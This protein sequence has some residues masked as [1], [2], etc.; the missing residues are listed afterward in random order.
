MVSDKDS[1][2][3]TDDGPTVQGLIRLQLDRYSKITKQLTNFRKD[4]ETRKTRMYFKKKIEQIEALFA[5]FSTD[6]K[7]IVCMDIDSNDDYFKSDIS[8]SFENAYFDVY[9][10]ICDAQE[11]AFPPGSNESSQPQQVAQP[12]H[13]VSK[14]IIQVPNL[15]VPKFSGRIIDWPGF[16]DNFNRMFN[17]NPDLNAIQRFHFLKEA[18]PDDKDIDIHQ[19]TMTEANYK[20]AWDLLA[21]RYHIPR[22]LF[23]HNMNTLYNLPSL[24]KEK[25]DDI[26]RML[27]VATVCMTAMEKIDIPIRECDHWIAHFLATKLSKETH[28]AWEYHLG[29]STSVPT[30]ARF[31]EFLNNRLI[32]LD[33]IENRNTS[34]QSDQSKQ[35]DATKNNSPSKGNKKSNVNK[36]NVHSTTKPDTTTAACPL[37]QGQHTIRR[38]QDFLSKTCYERKKD[39]DQAKICVNCLGFHHISKC[40]SSKN[41]LQCG[42]RHHTLLHFPIVV[43]TPSTVNT[44]P[45]LHTNNTRFLSA[46]ATQDGPSSK[47]LLATALVFAHNTQNNR[48]SVLRALIDQGSE[49][50]L[51]SERAVQTLQL[52]RTATRAEICGVG[53]GNKN[54]CRFIVSLNLRSQMDKH[55]D[56]FISNAY[57]LDRLSSRLPSQRLNIRSWPHTRDLVLADPNFHQSQHIDLIIGADIFAQIILPDIRIGSA[58]QP[59]AQRTKFGWI[60]SGKTSSTPEIHSKLQCFH[61][62]KELEFLVQRFMEIDQVPEKRVLSTEDEWCEEFF[63]RTHVRQANGKYMVRL[64][65]KTILDP[66]QTIG[67]SRQMALNRFHQ[68]HRKLQRNEKLN[69]QYSKGIEEYFELNQILPAPTMEEQH[70]VKSTSDR[71]F[72]TACTLPHHAIIKEDS[73]TTKVRI[74]FDASAKTSNGKSL[75]DILCIGP[76]L[77]NDLPAI[78]LNWRIHKFV[79]CA[80]IQKMYRCIDMHPDD[81]HYQR[82]LWQGNENKI[83]EYCLT[84]VTF[85]T[86]SAPYTAIRIM[87]QLAEDEKHRFPLAEKV[88]KHEMYVDDIQTGSHSTENCIEI[89]NQLI[90]ALHSG[91]FELRKWSSNSTEI[92]QSIPSEHQSICPDVDFEK[93]MHVKTLGLRWQPS[94]DI[95][96]YKF[97][98]EFESRITKRSILSVT[99]RLYDPLGFI[100]PIIT[101]AKII[102][103]TIWTT[104]VKDENDKLCAV[105]WDENLPSN[106]ETK[107]KQFL[108]DLRD[109]ENI[110]IPRWLKYVPHGIKS[111]QLHAFCDGSSTAYAA[112]VYLR[113]QYETGEIHTQLLIAKSKVTPT[114]PITIPRTELCGAV[115]AAKLV[116]WVIRNINLPTHDRTPVYYWT[117]ATIVLHWIYGDLNRW[118]TFVANRISAILTSSTH[119][120]WNHVDT[121]ENPADCATRGLSPKQLNEFELWWNGPAWLTNENSEYPKFNI[122]D[123]EVHDEQME[124]K[125]IKASVNIATK[126]SE[127][128]IHKYSSLTKLVRITAYVRRYIHNLRAKQSDRRHTGMLSTHEHRSSLLCL[129]RLVQN[130]SFH[131]EKTIIAKNES[132]PN[133]N[134]L[135]KLTP[136]IDKQNILR[137]RGRL[138][139][140]KFSYDRKHPMI[141]PASH[142][143]TWLIIN[144]SHHNTLHGGVQLTLTHIRTRFWIIDSKRT[145]QNQLR[146]CVKCFRIKPIGSKQLMGNLPDHRVNPPRRAFTA[147]GIDFTGAIELSAARLR[148]N[149]SYKG[150]IAIFICL[151]TKAIH[152][153]AV[154][155]MTAVHFLW[156][157]QRFIGRRGICNDIYSDCGTNFVGA[158]KI[159]KK[160]RDQFLEDMQKDVLPV[161]TV[162]NIKWHFNPPHSPNFG[163]LWEANVKSVKHHLKRMTDSNRLTYEE[164]STLLARIE[165][166]LNSRPLCPL[167]ADPDELFV[168][169]PGHFLIGDTLLSPPEPVT[170][171]EF[172]MPLSK[173]YLELQRMMQI[174]WRKW[175]SDWLSHLQSRPKWKSVETNIDINDL[176]LIRDDR[177]PPNEWLLGRVIEIHPGADGLVRVTTLRT[178]NGSYKRS[179][180]KLCRLPI[181]TYTEAIAE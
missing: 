125:S 163:G 20:V 92:M 164:L 61:V 79:F 15:S 134:K 170:N 81:V 111:I 21:K 124:A 57:V 114:K 82:I 160:Q 10:T 94:A 51:I 41:C 88:L 6:D 121:H 117:D 29:S 156:A 1:S 148:G 12:I 127:S 26:K 153:E 145:V 78:L 49:I 65:L 56:L 93:E 116:N 106:I 136:F 140:T 18:L 133:K 129:V 96:M 157:L 107:W 11:I 151:A 50:T 40:T 13:T 147:T 128:F 175:S 23:M 102:L 14:Q 90:D 28:Q 2:S 42:S 59:I 159:L 89:R 143:F 149:V 120:Q 119:E 37:C 176:V 162:Q 99:A 172:A 67:K 34:L 63:K 171:H 43:S 25:A 98:F 97:N 165:A 110:Q 155:G 17:L 168:L 83:S 112:N 158:D 169:T 71:P 54:S 16:H 46:T 87:H 80:D 38:C 123:I 144:E 142:H 19:M 166:C 108:T 4:S 91:G 150:Y 76:P 35:T 64:P 86:A 74:V 103:K 77:Q 31:E 72:V 131:H 55:F 152:L 44:T 70:V 7:R 9:C 3:E 105:G 154:T 177:L 100:A 161:L 174:F 32:T 109:I 137:V 173:R 181:P 180:S 69:K 66:T 24:S 58:D 104:K 135:S 27:N 115:L 138:H 141:L 33:V 48:S 85:G 60:L 36:Q 45:I 8:D 178:K 118:K 113:I 179:V 132:L 30:F 84:T 95:F 68:L 62:N 130:D 5:D 122:N 146:K 101:V 126:R 22:V 52:Q 167:S 47:V 139:R 39:V 53:N 75:N 73:L